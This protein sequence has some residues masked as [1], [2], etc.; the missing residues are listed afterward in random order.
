MKY[1]VTTDVS[2]LLTSLNKSQRLLLSRKW[3]KTPYTNYLYVRLFQLLLVDKAY[4]PEDLSKRI[5]SLKPQQLSNVQNELYQKVLEA[6]RNHQ[7]TTYTEKYQEMVKNYLILNG[8][9]LPQQATKW[10]KKALRFKQDHNEMCNAEFIN[11]EIFYREGLSTPSPQ[12]THLLANASTNN[13]GHLLQGYLEFRQF[14]LNY[15]FSKNETEYNQLHNQLLKVIRNTN[16]QHLSLADQIVYYRMLYHYNYIQRNFLLCF[17]Y[18]SSLVSGY[19]QTGLA[20]QYN[21]IYLKFL[22][23]QLTS[24]FRLNAKKKYLRLLAKFRQIEFRTSLSNINKLKEIHVIYE[25]T[26]TLNVALINGDFAD[27]VEAFLAREHRFNLIDKADNNAF[28][29]GIYY[30]VACLCFGN[31]DFKIC[32]VYLDKILFASNISARPDLQIFARILKLTALFELQETAYIFE[33]IRSV[34]GY[35]ARNK[36]LDQFSI[37]IMNFLR[38]CTRIPTSE[39]PQEFFKLREIMGKLALDKFEQRAFYYFD[40]ISWLDSKLEQKSLSKIIKERGLGH[41]IMY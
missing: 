17:K 8:L 28:V 25:L 5:P 32:L 30:K 2:E 31:E 39:L 21:E 34:Y 16:L 11:E 36:Q 33:N 3:S 41:R 7:E 29:I 18:A 20:K 26:H 1:K 27:G 23:Y 19:E 15:R 24:L 38:I 14:Y 6:L 22:N 12:D 9:N 37:E 4:T 10:K 35:L 13:T 40:I